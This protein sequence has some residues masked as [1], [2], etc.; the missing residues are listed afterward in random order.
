MY[1]YPL[2]SCSPIY[3]YLSA[4]YFVHENTFLNMNYSYLVQGP[5]RELCVHSM[6]NYIGWLAQ[7]ARNRISGI[8]R[9]FIP[10]K[11]IPADQKVTYFKREAKIFP[12]KNKTHCVWNY[13]GCNRLSF[14]GV[15]AMQNVSLVTNIIVISSR[16]SNPGGV[17]AQWTSINS[18]T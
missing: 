16:I 11:K 18:T 7:G 13:A 17:S 3:P 1:L 4:N 2:H 12:H 10:R 5:D 15:M 8:K 14:T 6:E 9:Y